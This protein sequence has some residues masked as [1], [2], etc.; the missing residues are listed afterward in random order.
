MNLFSELKFHIIDKT[1]LV[2]KQK[3]QTT[4]LYESR[5]EK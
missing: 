4:E 2:R 3:Q 5:H 1:V